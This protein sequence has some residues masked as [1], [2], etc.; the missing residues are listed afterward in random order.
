MA[1]QD[2]KKTTRSIK[3][4]VSI[5]YLAQHSPEAE[6]DYLGFCNSL[7]QDKIPWDFED[8]RFLERI[9]SLEEKLLGR[10]Q[11]SNKENVVKAG[12]IAYSQTLSP[13]EREGFEL[14]LQKSQQ[15][16]HEH[17]E[18][19]FGHTKELVDTY[20]SKLK[21]QRVQITPD[22]E[23][24]LYE[25]AR[26]AVQKSLDTGSVQDAETNLTA[27][28]HEDVKLTEINES[29]R[30]ASRNSKIAEVVLT[31]PDEVDK[32]A[33]VQHCLNLPD[34]DP[35]F[36]AEKHS[37]VFEIEKTF[38]LPDKIIE[39]VSENLE[40]PINNQ[41]AIT[42]RQTA[43][44]Q[45]TEQ[46]T[47]GATRPLEDVINALGGPG[48]KEAFGNIAAALI[49]KNLEEYHEKGTFGGIIPTPQA[50]SKITQIEQTLSAATGKTSPEEIS[51]AFFLRAATAMGVKPEVVQKAVIL[52]GPRLQ[53]GIL[54]YLE[55]TTVNVSILAP[56]YWNMIAL[57]GT[58]AWHALLQGA[59]Q[60]ISQ[61]A[62][63]QFLGQVGPSLV[64]KAGEGAAASTIVKTGFTLFSGV[65]G[66]F[67]SAALLLGGKFLSFLRLDGLIDGILGRRA[68]EEGR[69][70]WYKELGWILA[71]ISVAALLFCT[72]MTSLREVG[73]TAA[74][75]G[76]IDEIPS[77]TAAN[78][79]PS[80]PTTSA[81][82]ISVVI[83]PP[84]KICDT[85]TG[86]VCVEFQPGEA[87]KGD[88]NC[89]SGTESSDF[90]EA[91]WAMVQ[92][93]LDIL[94]QSPTFMSY[95]NNGTPITI[96]RNRTDYGGGCFLYG[97]NPRI[98]LYDDAFSSPSAM[99]YTLAHELGHAIAHNNPDLLNSFYSSG[100]IASE[101]Y[102]PSYPNEK[103][104]GEDFAETLGMYAHYLDSSRYGNYP[105]AFP[106]HFAFAQQVFGGA[107]I[108]SS[109]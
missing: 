15:Q 103:S 59:T 83:P 108:K 42:N 11:L 58:N 99:L 40:K 48:G 51:A 64:G 17:Q 14:G 21:D 91:E 35:V 93:A 90:T 37:G 38:R 102:L 27:L 6:G 80:S 78:G 60:N 62:I 49:G 36:I 10:L 44:R 106:N 29:I 53:Q 66:K 82:N 87:G 52:Y 54:V 24:V 22:Q 12:E 95:V 46:I 9:N 69:T 96:S 16:I 34:Q 72:G 33:L 97:N 56:E 8:N 18:A 57:S 71:I 73:S 41:S 20:V 43:V 76:E 107:T 30:L 92:N 23:V 88:S 65:P 26:G 74:I 19:V 4:V 55:S 81:K 28:L 79:W 109:P 5:L 31:S 75:I 39:A 47:Q 67:L 101:G 61:A 68:I 98:I 70:P 85:A 50:I 7:A 89:G 100:I 2:P 86:K 1:D 84:I 63:K 94:S 105:N 25:E 104:S 13:E 3:E 45:A 32:A 77:E